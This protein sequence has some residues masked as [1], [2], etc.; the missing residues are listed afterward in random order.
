VVGN[1]GKGDVKWREMMEK[2][3]A[4]WLLLLLLEGTD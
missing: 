2:G 4:G 3:A 1:G